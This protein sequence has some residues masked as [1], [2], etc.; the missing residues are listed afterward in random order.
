MTVVV[1]KDTWSAQFGNQAQIQI[2]DCILQSSFNRD[3]QIIHWTALIQN[4]RYQVV[5]YYK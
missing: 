1:R 5:K 3:R 4:F 2:S